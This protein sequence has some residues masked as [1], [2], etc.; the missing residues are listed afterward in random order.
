MGH[1]AY[2]KQPICIWLFSLFICIFVFC[3]FIWFSFLCQKHFSMHRLN[4]SQVDAKF[5]IFSNKQFVT[6]RG[7]SSINRWQWISIRVNTTDFNEH[8]SRTERF[9]LAQ[10]FLA[11]KSL[12]LSAL[13]PRTLPS[14]AVI[15]YENE[16]DCKTCTLSRTLR[17]VYIFNEHL[18]T[19]L[20]KHFN[21]SSHEENWKLSNDLI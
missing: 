9:L 12:M 16:N 18:C 20:H 5:E 15:I 11:S 19:P 3:I 10:H 7:K 17:F 2:C 4:T 6:I 21:T 14:A 8:K 13:S 1:S